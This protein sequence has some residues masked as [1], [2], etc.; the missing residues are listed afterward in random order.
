MRSRNSRNLSG[1]CPKCGAKEAVPILYGM[2]SEEGVR[3]IAKGEI[4]SGG[5]CIEDGQ[6]QWR[7]KACGHAWGST[8]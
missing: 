2:P 1:D 5:C 6:P 3:M 8:T 4:E 7:C